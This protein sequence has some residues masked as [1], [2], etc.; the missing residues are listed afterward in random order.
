MNPIERA[1][2]SVDQWQ[3]R[4]TPA[5]FVYGVIKKFGDDNG[6]VLVANLAH[7]AFVSLFP[8]L[9]L[10]VTILGVVLRNPAITHDVLNSV[11]SQV[12]IIG[13]KLAS[14]IHALQRGSLLGLIVGVLGLIWGSTGLAQAG[15]FAMEQTWNIPGKVRP[16]YFIRLARSLAFLLV[17]GLGVILTTGLATLGTI[18]GH[19]ALFRVAGEAGSAAL[20][21]GVLF[22]V[23]RI[24]TPKGVA[25]RRLV[26]GAVAGAVAWTL[27][28]AVGGY[29]LAH[30]FRNEAPVY[31]FF[32]IVLGLVAWVYFTAEVVVYAAEVNV[33]LALHLWPR[34]IVQPPLTRADE[35]SL[36]L[37]ATENARRPEQHVQVWFDPPAIDSAPGAV[38]ALTAAEQ[39]PTSP[40]SV[41]D[42][43]ADVDTGGAPGVA[44]ETGTGSGRHDRMEV[45]PYG[46]ASP[47]TIHTVDTRP[48]C[49]PAPSTTES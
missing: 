29:L 22:L 45:G 13:T 16:N 31:G 7:A 36:T 4:H 28:Q 2:R 47:V 18:G 46:A 40:S 17:L 5:A 20:N 10:T 35:I 39:P 48:E 33:V 19:T 41:R 49:E 30:D 38:G 3:Q 14:N 43:H 23:F 37:Q 15:V 12:P 1:A 34:A 8:L 21:A 42:P 9:L 27:L 24:L 6:G 26:P 32:A 25:T 11:L 44:T